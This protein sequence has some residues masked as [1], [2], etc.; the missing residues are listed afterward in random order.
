MTLLNPYISFKD[1]ARSAMEFYQSV[2]GGDLTVSTFGDYP[3][4]GQDES[5]ND[6]VMHAQLTTADG[7]TLMGSDT[8]T[9]MTYEKP[10]G[11]AV[12]LSGDDESTLQRYWDGLA[13]DGTVTLPF[14][15]PPWGGRF[16]MLTDKFGVEWMVNV[17]GDQ[18]PTS[19]LDATATNG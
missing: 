10:A 6:L 16:G 2:L 18:P 13:A 4:M 1:N 5:E 14:E 15:V 12:S 7:L 19:E 17:S 8:P 11:V 3:G 9:R